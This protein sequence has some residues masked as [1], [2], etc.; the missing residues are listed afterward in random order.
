MIPKGEFA[1]QFVSPATYIIPQALTRVE[2]TII[3]IAIVL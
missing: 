3:K 2:Y 1:Y